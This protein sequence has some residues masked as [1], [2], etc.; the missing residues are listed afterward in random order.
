[1]QSISICAY[2]SGQAPVPALSSEP[3]SRASQAPPAPPLTFNLQMEK[4]PSGSILIPL[5][6]FPTCKD[7]SQLVTHVLL[8]SLGLPVLSLSQVRVK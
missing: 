6:W 8:A 2:S 5:I 7:A 1:M 4:S 3:V